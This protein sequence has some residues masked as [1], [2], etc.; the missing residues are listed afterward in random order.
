MIFISLMTLPTVAYFFPGFSPVWLRYFP[1]Y[2][3]LFG[4]REAIFPSGNPQIIYQAAL[5]LVAANL[6]ALALSGRAFNRR[7]ARR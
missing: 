5:Y 1:T 3:I 6:A 7:L 4:L 2:P